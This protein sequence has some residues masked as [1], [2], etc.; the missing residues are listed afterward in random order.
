MSLGS[1]LYTYRQMVWSMKGK[2][3]AFLLPTELSP[4]QVSDLSPEAL[5]VWVQFC[6]SCY[7]CLWS[8]GSPYL[9]TNKKTALA[10]VLDFFGCLICQ[11]VNQV[12]ENSRI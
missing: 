10:W 9:F 12:Y 5:W 2:G 6:P 3:K 4:V 11:I 8:Q 7:Q 1:V